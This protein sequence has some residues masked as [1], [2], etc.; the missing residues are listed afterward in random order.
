MVA[1]PQ[2]QKM[3]VEVY[4]AWERCQDRRYEYAHGEVFAMT[5]GSLAH[6]DIAINI[7]TALRPQVRGEG[8]RINIAD[9]K[10]QVT[11]S[12]YRYPD[13]VV[14]CDPQ[15]QRATDAIQHPKLIVEVLSPGTEALDRGDKFKEYRTLPTLMEYVLVSS[16]EINVEVYRRGEGRLWLYQ[17]YQTGDTIAL[18]SVGLALPMMLIYDTV[19]LGN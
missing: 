11:P 19:T 8:C 4:L 2:P 7:L 1:T 17:A 9:A 13:L 15:D 18:K 5:G 3:T 12:I 10:V 16:T 6:N 14:S